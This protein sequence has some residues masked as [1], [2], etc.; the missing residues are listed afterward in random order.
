MFA[1]VSNLAIQTARLTPYA[2]K[3]LPHLKTAGKII[4]VT[5][6]IYGG[7]RSSANVGARVVRRVTAEAALDTLFIEVDKRGG[8][9]TRAEYVELTKDVPSL[10]TRRAAKPRMRYVWSNT[11]TSFAAACGDTYWLYSSPVW[12]GGKAL[13]LGL[14]G[15]GYAALKVKRGGR[16]LRLRERQQL[17]TWRG[18][19]GRYVW[20][21]I[22]AISWSANDRTTRVWV[23]GLRRDMCEILSTEW[24]EH[25]MDRLKSAFDDDTVEDAFDE[26]AKKFD[27]RKTV[28]PLHEVL[29]EVERTVVFDSAEQSEPI[30]QPTESVNDRSIAREA[31]QAVGVNRLEI[32]YSNLCVRNGWSYESY[33]REHP[34]EVGQAVRKEIRDRHRKQLRTCRAALPQYCLA[35]G[36]NL[37]QG[38]EFMRGFENARLVVA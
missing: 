24:I 30:E 28:E 26:V 36:L 10:R 14:D 15:A 13:H 38:E 16:K 12:A 19:T 27:F 32:T 7:A 9:L 11:W 18:W 17:A 5:T 25:Q 8:K 20:R 3:V 37:K 23:E 2:V 22:S 1:V 29:D 35:M 31:T 34:Y 21:P 33:L 6:V 4:A